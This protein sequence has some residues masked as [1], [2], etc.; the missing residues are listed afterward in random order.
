MTAAK[1]DVICLSIIIK[2]LW[3][4][5]SSK[6]EN[7]LTCLKS[8][9]RALGCLEWKKLSQYLHS[10]VESRLMIKYG[11]LR[12]EFGGDQDFPMIG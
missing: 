10:L 11:M 6:A 2:V 3:K 4:D 1:S 5:M 7:E 9:R 8:N 12:L